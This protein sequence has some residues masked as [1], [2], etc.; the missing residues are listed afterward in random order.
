MSHG[1][2]RPGA[3]HGAAQ[4]LPRQAGRRGPCAPDV[5]QRRPLRTEAAGPGKKAQESRGAP[6]PRARAERAAGMCP[7]TYLP[8]ARRLC[9][10]RARGGALGGSG[11]P[12]RRLRTRSAQTQTPR[13]RQLGRAG[14][15]C[16]NDH[17]SSRS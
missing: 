10:S 7:G 17:G 12:E 2:S 3:E 8:A 16:L 4:V 9:G 11:P 5:T 15:A 14:V 1:E 6:T 13:S